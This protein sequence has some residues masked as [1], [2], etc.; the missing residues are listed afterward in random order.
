MAT[1]TY[2]Q[3][4]PWLYEQ[5]QRH[6]LSLA[7]VAA[8]VGMSSSA[9]SHWTAGTR[10]PSKTTVGRIAAALEVAPSSVWDLLEREGAP[11]VVRSAAD[12]PL[13]AGAAP[14]GPTIAPEDRPFAAWLRSELAARD[15]TT[16]ALARRLGVATVTVRT[17]TKGRSTPAS[18]QVPRIA[19]ALGVPVETIEELLAR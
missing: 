18:F 17:W 9:A 12:V 11:G 3:F 1:T 13:V 6:A 15:W 7:D 5:F 10:L 16:G 14:A 2:T 4:G 8:R 19:A